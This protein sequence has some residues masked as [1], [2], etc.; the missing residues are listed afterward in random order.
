MTLA[1]HRRLNVGVGQR[2]NSIEGF[3]FLNLLEGILYGHS[4]E[5]R[6]NALKQVSV[7]GL[8]VCEE[9]LIAEWP[10]GLPA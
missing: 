5:L 9:S 8:F 1:V 10:R 4:I 3:Y 7:P 6:A 2:S